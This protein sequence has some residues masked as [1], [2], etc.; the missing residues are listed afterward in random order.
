M[1]S[2]TA[3]DAAGDVYLAGRFTNTVALGGTTLTSVGGSDV[4]VTK[5]NAASNQFVWAQR[6]G[7]MGQDFVSAMAVSGT[8]V[9]VAGSYDGAVSGFGAT[10]LTNAGSIGT[11]DIFVAKLTDTGSFVWAQRAGGTDN[12][13]A[14]ALAVSG[15]S[16][17]V[18]GEFTSPTAGFGPTVLSTAG[19]ADVYVADVYV[20]KLTDAGSTGSFAWA[21]RAGG[22]H[23]DA[24]YALAVSGTSVYVAGA[25]HSPTAGFGPTVLPT[26]GTA[27]VY[28]AKLTDAGS[29]VWAQRAGGTGSDEAY[30]LAI[31]GTSVFV[32]GTFYSPTTSF[33]AISL[34]NPYPNPKKNL[35]FLASL[36]DPTLTAPA[37]S[38]EPASLYPNP[39]RQGAT[40]A[41]PR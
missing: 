25:F 4:F 9:Y 17:Y 24:A 5:F 10:T 26:A 41:P 20:T 21:Q 23:Y 40:P 19:S 13:Y 1:V 37:D 14:Q 12:D 22:T 16:V 35:G 27:D 30:A 2:A 28:V 34:T 18:A 33:G 3:V 36:T 7:G 39:A 8:S 15:A 31:S 6:A 32:A 29:F 11:N 38:R